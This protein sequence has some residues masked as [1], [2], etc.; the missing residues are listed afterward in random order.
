[1]KQ[2]SCR[3][4]ETGLKLS[5]VI[6]S[7][8]GG[9]LLSRHLPEVA[10][11]ASRL[12]AGGEV[13]VV[14]DSSETGLE[15][16]QAAVERAGP[17]ARLVTTSRHLGFSGA[18]NRGAQ[19]ARGEYLF[20]LNNDMALE[21]D[22][23]ATLIARLEPHPEW[24]ALSPTIFNT[25]GGFVESV[26]Q[27][28]WVRGALDVSFPGRASGP[29]DPAPGDVQIA[30]PCG[31]AFLCRRDQFL[32]LGG[33]ASLCAPFYWEDAELGLRAAAQGLGCMATSAARC[34]HEH[35]QTIGR[36]Y[37]AWQIKQIY[38]R[39]RWLVTWTVLRGGEAWLD[40][41]WWL[42]WRWLAALVRARPGAIALPLALIRVPQVWARRP[43]GPLDPVK[44]L[45]QFPG[46]GWPHCADIAHGAR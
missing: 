41:L 16:T 42:P 21:A 33:F 25:A 9:D 3:A 15:Q 20:F 13:V 23:L 4:N 10:R 2:R 45:R 31:G 5:V 26:T 17:N 38:E 44:A 22:C 39:N 37:S 36:Q 18:C 1:V 43:A 29:S 6:P 12:P 34:R 32:R 30:Y 24:F 35:A 7:R 19:E 40:H 28:V 8:S 14:D 11:Q 46:Q 27:L